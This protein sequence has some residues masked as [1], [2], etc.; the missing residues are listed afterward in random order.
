MVHC[1]E[2]GREPRIADYINDKLVGCPCGVTYNV[3]KIAAKPQRDIS[4]SPA[5]Q[6]KKKDY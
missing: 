6:R 4:G 3:D 2:C 1:P 5:V